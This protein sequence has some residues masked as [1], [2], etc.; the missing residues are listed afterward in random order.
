MVEIG[1][2]HLNLKG[3]TV[4]NMNSLKEGQHFITFYIYYLWS[5][6][7]NIIQRKDVKLLLVFGPHGH[8]TLFK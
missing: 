8:P 5:N 4:T 3:M 7:F 2:F 1:N 6:L